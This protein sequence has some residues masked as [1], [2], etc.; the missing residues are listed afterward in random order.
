MEIKTFGKITEIID[1]NLE[2]NFP[3]TISEL[4]TILEEKFPALSAISYTIAIDDVLINDAD[5]SIEQPKTIAI[6]PPFSGG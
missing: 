4:K 2:I 6:L 5:E 1:K 3:I